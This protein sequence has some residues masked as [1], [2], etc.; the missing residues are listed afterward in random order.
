LLNNTGLAQ[1]KTS[2]N[3]SFLMFSGGEKT[4]APVISAGKWEKLEIFGSVPVVSMGILSATEPAKTE[5]I[6]DGIGE[7]QADFLGI[8]GE[9]QFFDIGGGGGGL[10][11][12]PVQNSPGPRAEAS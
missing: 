8:G 9:I 3:S 7:S 10:F 1:K 4:L 2:G 12:E 5:E 6:A 11:A